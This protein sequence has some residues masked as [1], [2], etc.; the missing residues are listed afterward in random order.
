V[1][2]LREGFDV[3]TLDAYIRYFCKDT[4]SFLDYMK[5]VGNRAVCTHSEVKR[6]RRLTRKRQKLQRAE[7]QNKRQ[8]GQGKKLSV[9]QIG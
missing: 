2:S 7:C 1:E 3:Q 5:D 9:T 4:V 8:G 6:E